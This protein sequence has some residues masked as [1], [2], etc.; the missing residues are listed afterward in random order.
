MNINKDRLIWDGN[1]FCTQNEL[2]NTIKKKNKSIKS[3]SVN[4]N[5]DSRAR[6]QKGI[7]K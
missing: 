7:C 4:T 5:K 3:W 6:K 2:N 1:K